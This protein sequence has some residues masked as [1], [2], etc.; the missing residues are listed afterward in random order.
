MRKPSLAGRWRDQAAF[1]AGEV[2][3]GPGAGVG[4]GPAAVMEG[5]FQ[6]HAGAFPAAAGRGEEPVGIAVP[7]PEAA[8]GWP[9][10]G[11]LH[12]VQSLPHPANITANHAALFPASP[13][14]AIHGSK[15]FPR[16]SRPP[17]PLT[18]WQNEL[19]MTWCQ[20]TDA[21]LPPLS[22]TWCWRGRKVF[23]GNLLVAV[24]VK[25]LEPVFLLVF[26]QRLHGGTGSKFLE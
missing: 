22:L 18:G 12:H 2:H 26:G 4:H 9:G 3:G 23:R 15:L 17:P 11:L 16:N 25:Q 1:G 21:G 7:G 24:A 10:V 20:P 5:L 8:L 19:P 14:D 6:G 13:L